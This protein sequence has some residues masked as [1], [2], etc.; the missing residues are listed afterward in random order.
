MTI[1]R[2]LLLETL[3]G[4]LS[5]VEERRPRS[6]HNRATESL[7]KVLAESMRSRRARR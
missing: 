6:A 5:L 1:Q 3:R 4:H 7:R 2:K